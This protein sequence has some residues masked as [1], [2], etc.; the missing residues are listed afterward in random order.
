M[1][2]KSCMVKKNS[3]TLI[4]YC[5]TFSI[6][7]FILSEQNFQLFL[8][9]LDLYRYVYLKQVSLTLPTIYIFHFVNV[10]RIDHLKSRIMCE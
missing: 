1:L 9:S 3:L 2:I 4:D 5:H 8:K 7:V 10:P 6:I